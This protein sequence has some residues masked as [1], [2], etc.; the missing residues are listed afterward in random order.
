MQVRKHGIL[1]A[2]TVLPWLAVSLLAGGVLPIQAAEEKPAPP[3][4]RSSFGWGVGD[5]VPSLCG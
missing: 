2:M 3:P 1:G 5:L 4:V